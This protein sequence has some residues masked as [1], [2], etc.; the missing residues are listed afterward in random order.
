[1]KPDDAPTR[2][3]SANPAERL[4]D[5]IEL[6]IG[7][8]G[9]CDPAGDGARLLFCNVP[10]TRW[11]GRSSAELVGG[12]LAELF[13]PAAWAA[14]REA[15]AAAFEGRTVSYERRLTHQGASARWS[16]IQVFPDR[17]E[18]GQVEAVYTIAFDIHQDV[19]ERESLLAARQRLDRFTE[20]IPYPLTYVDR[21]Y[22]LSFVNLAYQQAVGQSAAHLLGRPIGEVRGP[23][24]WAQHKPFFDRAL[25]GEAVQY[26]R[27][28]RDLPQGDR[29]MRTHYVPDFD[30]AGA[31]VGCYT[32]TI[33][34]H[35]LTEAQQRLAR[36]V[37]RDHLTDALSRRTMMERLDAAAAA[38]NEQAMA[39]FF[40]DLDGFKALNDAAGH[41]AGDEFLVALARALEG[42]VRAED[43]VG[44]FGGDEFLVLASVRD[45]AGAAVL[46]QHLQGA[47]R[48]C[49]QARPAAGAVSAS[50]GYALAPHDATQPL[51]WLQLADNA[52]YAAK[53]EGKNRVVHCSAAL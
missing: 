53:R 11:A 12:T 19:V 3:L 20:H 36:S 42:A 13:G 43:A 46:A 27:L 49:A 31:I 23:A 4:V 10:Y 32:V 16:R 9:R 44:R 17:D 37:E 7:R 50:I 21:A 40:I 52:M 41:A 47:V 24:R 1:M 5:A 28:V 26:T 29:W 45:A 6:P 22:R 8:W 39:L 30:D 48:L 15:F 14:A 18:Q 2:A 38:S 35:D 33:D 34:V 51:R 25:A